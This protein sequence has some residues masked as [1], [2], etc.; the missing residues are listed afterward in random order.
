MILLRLLRVFQ[1]NFLKGSL[2]AINGSRVQYRQPASFSALPAA[3]VAS[4]GAREEGE[5]ACAKRDN[6][7]DLRDY[8]MMMMMMIYYKKPVQKTTD[9]SFCQWCRVYSLSETYFAL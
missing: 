9:K 7:H 4:W 2:I 1:C 8:D 3:A 5:A 6:D